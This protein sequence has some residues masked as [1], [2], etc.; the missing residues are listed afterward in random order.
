[1]RERERRKINPL[2]GGDHLADT[3]PRNDL[4]DNPLQE[5]LGMAFPA[6]PEGSS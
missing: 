4:P 3:Q 1:M 6:F 2:R 5:T